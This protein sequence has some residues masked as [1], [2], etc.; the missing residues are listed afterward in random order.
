MPPLPPGPP[1]VLVADD[2]EAIC[3]G[4]RRLL[5]RDGYVVRVASDGRAAV[6]VVRANGR[7]VRAAFLDVLMPGLNGL[8][9]LDAIRRVAPWVRCTLMTAHR[10]DV[11]LG[12][13]IDRAGVGILEKPFDADDLRAALGPA[14]GTREPPPSNRDG[15]PPTVRARRVAVVVGGDTPA[16]AG[17]LREVQSFAR[18]AGWLVTVRDSFPAAGDAIDGVIATSP[19][20]RG[21]FPGPVVVAVADG[22][23]AAAALEQLLANRRR[24]PR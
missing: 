4:L 21:G 22:T 8:A 13:Q 16:R 10:E 9:A 12:P 3:F 15:G 6:D 23:A 17:V 7:R 24:P 18:A 20:G 2:E 14:A 11:V 19:A 1:E 5:E